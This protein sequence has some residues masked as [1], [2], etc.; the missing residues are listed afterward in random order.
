MGW[1]SSLLAVLLALVTAGF[2]YLQTTDDVVSP[3]DHETRARSRV[4]FWLTA[5]AFGF[6]AFRAFG[7]LL[8]LD[9]NEWKVQSANNLGDLALHITYIRNL[10]SGVPLWPENPIYVFSYLRY[11]VGTDLFNSVLLLLGV[12]L[13]RGL[14]WAGLLGSLATFYA[15]YRW[16]G[17]FTVAGF[18]FNGGLAGFQILKTWQLADFQGTSA[19]A[20]KNLALSMFV[21]QRGLLY[22]LPAGLLL[23][24]QWRA[25]FQGNAFS[26]TPASAEPHAGVLEN[27]APCPFWV[28][29]ALYASMPLFHVHTFIVL[30]VVAASL[31]LFGYTPLRRHFLWLV[32]L[33]F[34]PATLLVYL[35]TD[36]FRAK[37]VLGWQPGWVQGVDQFAPT[38]LRFWLENFGILM[39]LVLLL[40]VV[41][42]YRGW[43]L[44]RPGGGPSFLA[45]IRSS[46]P[47]AFLLPAAFI[48]LFACFVKTAPWGWDNIKLIIWAYLIMLP[49]LWRELIVRWP[50]PVRAGICFALFFSGFVS[51]AGGLL[52]PDNGYTFADRA[53]LDGVGVA[54][55]K[56]PAT[57]RFAAFPTYNHPLLLQGRKLVLGYPGH[58][59]TQ[60]FNYSAVENQLN[61]L[62]RDG[63]DW[64]KQA[65][66]LHVRYLFWGREEKAH[67]QASTRPWEREAKPVAS[68]PW[69]AIYDL[70]NSPNAPSRGQ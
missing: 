50:V 42:A 51:L 36:Y 59:W 47:W 25:R 11:P 70:E 43:Q 41:L 19:I 54:V 60:G 49:F 17:P 56:L 26:K 58:L 29:L 20:W 2:A 39:P 23:L 9:G 24:Y 69:G 63:P 6:L 15:L 3:N 48:F 67:Y 44:V 38:F 68:G 28:E 7:W 45:H 12:D 5:A 31:F 53:E 65:S 55:E 66:A 10:A 30:S 16:G 34:L 57:A 46:A 61:A 1:S 52:N 22:A 32:G 62:M 40:F 21:T 4:W 18:L 35:I 8:Y 13:A 14:I 33:A 37:S 64:K 27:A